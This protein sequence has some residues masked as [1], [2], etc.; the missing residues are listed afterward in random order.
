MVALE[1]VVPVLCQNCRVSRICVVY[2]HAFPSSVDHV[3]EWNSQFGEVTI[4]TPP[5]GGGDLEYCSGPYLWQAAVVEYLRAAPDVEGHTV[6]VGDDFVLA[7]GFDPATLLGDH[8]DHGGLCHLVWPLGSEIPGSW[9]WANRVATT[10]SRPT[11]PITGSGAEDC[12]AELRAS[13]LYRRGAEAIDQLGATTFTLAPDTGPETGW[14]AGMMRER[15]GAKGR[16]NTGVPLRGGLSDLF[17]FPNSHSSAV[18]DFLARTVRVNL[19]VE[20]AV[21]TMLAWS[22]LHLE[23]L[24]NRLDY[25]WGDDR[26]E[27]DFG[28]VDDV[29]G[30]L[31]QRPNLVGIHPVKWSRM[32]AANHGG[33]A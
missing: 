7:P 18:R 10:W 3:R 27:F 6:V 26:A 33:G 30:Y 25:R 17:S 5:G 13:E 16:V 1:S 2:N 15:T 24:G 29:V 11:A 32:L 23:R 8:V 9:V 4:V 14:W 12:A 21:P 20:V 28:S 22:G 31:E 19:F